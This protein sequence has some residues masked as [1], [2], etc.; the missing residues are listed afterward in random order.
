MK[1]SNLRLFE[2]NE[3]LLFLN[4][5]L[6]KEILNDYGITRRDSSTDGGY[7]SK[8][9]LGHCKSKGIVNIV[10]NKVVGSLQNI[11]SSLKMKTMLKRWCSGNEAVIPNL[12]RGFDL[13]VCTWKGGK[14]FKSKLMW[15][16][17]AYNFKVITNM[18][19]SRIAGLA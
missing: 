15:S 9:D 5:S 16:V 19:F 10:F 1:I 14:H 12:K 7:G 2:N 18:V 13:R 3:G 11:T 4:S 6:R 8:E 17:L